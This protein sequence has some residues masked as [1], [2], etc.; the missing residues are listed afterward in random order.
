MSSKPGP[1]LEASGVTVRVSGRPLLVDSSFHLERGEI[2]LLCGPSGTGKTVLLKI[3]CGILR[4]SS[5]LIE[6]SGSIRFQG[7]DLIKRRPPRGRIGILFQDHAL[8][9]EL[10]PRENVLFALRHRSLAARRASKESEVEE[11]ARLLRTLGLRGDESVRTMSG[12]QLQRLALARTLAQNPDLLLFDEPTTGLDPTNARRAAELIAAVH[13]QGARSSL[14]VT[15]DARLMAPL[16]RR[17]YLL[18]PASHRLEE[19]PLASL[20]ERLH[21]LEVD[22]VATGAAIRRDSFFL[23]RFLEGTWSTAL[24][25]LLAVLHLL[26]CQPRLR[27][28]LSYL[29]RCLSLTASIGA[30]AYVA[31]AAVL[32]GH[33]TTYFTFKYLPRRSFTEPLFVDDVLYAL[34][35]LLYRVLCPV[36]LTVLLAARSG[37]AIASYIGGKVYARQFD[38]LRSFGV[39]PSR[40]LLSG[41][42][43]AF[44]LSTPLLYALMFSLVALVNMMVFI[45]TH[46]DKT[47]FF[48]RQNYLDSLIIPGNL[49]PRGSLWLLFKLETCAFGTAAIAYFQG[50]RDKSS[51]D[52]V[53]RAVTRTIICACL[54][55]LFVHFL[56]AFFEFRKIPV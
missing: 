50:A 34:G 46:E 17:A 4:P 38:A 2:V 52:D 55:V 19:V 30:F 29:R 49:W 35:F 45:A 44:L 53:S 37:A 54:Y 51:A 3:L 43:W 33:V 14:V 18:D 27:Y 6:A 56:F 12:G 41:S 24:G 25:L 7:I 47:I 26:P 39:A 20:E 28:A 31:V 22:K 23:V 40:Y 21:H 42:L 36:M 9:D 5:T 15:H 1:L 32:L 11:S 48:W 16:A 13:Q 8:F 10:D